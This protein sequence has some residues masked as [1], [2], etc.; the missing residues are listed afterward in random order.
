MIAT[1]VYGLAGLVGSALKAWVSADQKTLSRKSIADVVIGAAV[2]ILYP[3]YPLVP[4]PKDA[5]LIQQAALIGVLAYVS[6]DF[7]QNALAKVGITLPGINPKP[8]GA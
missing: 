1:L 4:L 5:N 3:L 2:G 8:P 6:S 7:I